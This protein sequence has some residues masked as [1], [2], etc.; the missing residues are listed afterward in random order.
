[1]MLD[2]NILCFRTLA[3]NVVSDCFVMLLDF[4]TFTAVLA[5]RSLKKTTNKSARFEI[6]QDFR[7]SSHGHVKGLL[8]KCTV[9][10]VDFR[11]S[12]HGHVKG[13]LQK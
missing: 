1:M 11:P 13:L 10:E 7:P 4:N 5:A 8:Q 2:P 12:S 3:V 9:L 6:I